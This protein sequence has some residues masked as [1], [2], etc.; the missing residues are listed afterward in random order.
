ML[1][2]FAVLYRSKEVM[3]MTYQFGDAKFGVKINYRTGS[4][5]NKTK[6][7]GGVNSTFESIG[8]A[9][10]ASLFRTF[11]ELLMACTSDT[12]VSSNRTAEQPVEVV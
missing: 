2:D 4:E 1:F 6:T 8:S 7:L 11:G 5:Q 3:S 9:S 12:F 10:S